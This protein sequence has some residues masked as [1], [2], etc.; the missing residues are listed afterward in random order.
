MGAKKSLAESGFAWLSDKV[1]WAAMI[2]KANHRA[3]LLFNTPSIQSSY[4]SRYWDVVKIKGS[5]I[6]F[7]DAFSP[8][9]DKRNNRR[10]SAMILQ[11]LV[12]LTLKAFRIQVF[13]ELAARSR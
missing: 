1:D 7:H 2:F 8:L 4:R 3:N 12:D 9:S 13:E 5:F 10:S 11:P 6:I